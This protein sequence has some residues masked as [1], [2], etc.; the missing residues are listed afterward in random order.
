[1][2]STR[3]RAEAALAVL[4]AVV[5]LVV[6]GGAVWVM[7]RKPVHENAAA[8][9]STTAAAP[10]ERYSDAVKEGRRLARA[11]VVD[12]SLPGLSVAVAVDGDIVWAEGFGWADNSRTPVTPL[13]RF[14]LGALSKPLTAAAVALLHD[15]GRLDLDAPIQR[16]VRAY[17]EKQWTITTRQLMG[18]VAGVHRIRGDNND[19]MPV[20]HCASLDQAVAMLADDPLLFEPGTEHRYSIWG[21][22]LV[23]AVVQGAAAEPFAR[24][25]TRQ[26]FEPL[27][28]ERTV[29]AETEGLDGVVHRA[30]RRPDYSC[31]AGAGAFLSTP[32]DLVRLGSAM[33]KPGLLQADTIAAFQ[34]PTRLVSGASTT[35]A[36][37]WTVKSVQLAGE[38]ARIVSHRGSPAGGTGSLLTF[39]DL[40]LAIAAA[41]N[42]TDARGVDPFALQV[43]EAFTRRQNRNRQALP[44]HR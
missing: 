13:T 2:R 12:E 7:S 26:V 35:Y 4:F 27:A 43:A 21:W 20:S 34:A 28:M 33:L 42:V 24:F 44:M 8:V 40:G 37:G 38:P 41:A 39:P 22:V 15:R 5:I 9:P 10:P 23:S 30:G 36:L 6:G 18:D 32:T 29:V 1:V 3:W 16:Y 17:P 14:R 25:I 31:L 11:L 19:A